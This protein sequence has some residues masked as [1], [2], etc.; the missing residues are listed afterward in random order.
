MNHLLPVANPD[1]TSTDAL[2]DKK[3]R[4]FVG[5]KLRQQLL[6]GGYDLKMASRRKEGGWHLF[7]NADHELRKHKYKFSTL[8]EMRAWWTT[9]LRRLA[10]EDEFL[11]SFEGLCDDASDGL[12]KKIRDW[13]FGVPIP[14]M[15]A[16]IAYLLDEYQSAVKPSAKIWREQASQIS[17]KRSNESPT[18]LQTRMVQ[19]FL[20][21]ER[22]R[23]EKLPWAVKQDVERKRL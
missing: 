14:P 21:S 9:H 16:E 2:R 10:L 19:I 20:F 11:K 5:E 7:C 18:N 12:N 15:P 3:R 6:K 13:F 4:L 17:L 22:R 1:S 8:R 23:L